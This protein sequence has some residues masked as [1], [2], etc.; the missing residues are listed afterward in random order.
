MRPLLRLVAGALVAGVV[1]TGCTI[2]ASDLEET[3]EQYLQ[4]VERTLKPLRDS[5]EAFDEIYQDTTRRSVFLDGIEKI[6]YR[7]RIIRLFRNL[8]DVTPPPRFFRDQR[9]LLRA[10]VDMAPVARSA[11]EL[12]GGG[13][14]VKASSR[15]AHAY[16]LYERALVGHTSRFCLAAATSA[17]ERDL[18][19]PVGILPGA[20]YGDRLHDILAEASA[21]FTPRAFFFLAKIFDEEENARYLRSVG[22][23]QVDGVATARDELRKLVPPDEFAADHRILERYFTD[24]TRVSSQILFAA[25]NN[26]SLFSQIR[27]SQRLVRQAGN[28]LSRNIRPAVA[29]WFFPSE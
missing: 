6:P 14:L 22:P 1:L 4:R 20:G 9:R 21:E 13:E 29:V 19:D 25:N 18:C 10:L 17:A 24:I 26:R 16:V 27:E 12:A 5:T 11:E 28:G 3:E 8:Q 23:S 15:Y 2:E 7:R